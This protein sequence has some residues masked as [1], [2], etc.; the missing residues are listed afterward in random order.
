M[1]DRS[2]VTK[3]AE[4]LDPQKKYFGNR[5]ISRDDNTFGIFKSISRLFPSDSMV[6]VLDDSLVWGYCPNLILIRKF[7]FFNERKLNEINQEALL[8]IELIFKKDL[9]ISLHEEF[10]KIYTT[11]ANVDIKDIMINYRSNFLEGCKITFSQLI[12]KEESDIQNPFWKLAECLGGDCYSEI[13]QELT[14]II[15]L[16]VSEKILELKK[17]NPTIKSFHI[18]WLIEKYYLTNFDED[19]FS[20]EN[21]KILSLPIEDYLKIA[22]EIL[23]CYLCKIIDIDDSNSDSDSD[24][25]SDN[26]NDN[27]SNS[28]SDCDNNS[29]SNNSNQNHNQNDQND[30][31]HCN[32]DNSN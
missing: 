16:Q 15:S 27:D 6:L 21:N 7:I 9:L 31:N 17:I 11:D 3:I 2:Y 20:V 18:S 1:G 30:K 23:D 4:I 22:K 28:N 8:D 13:H 5:L 19:F 29:N 12:S 25:N 10:Y 26:D 24:S 14:H 32:Y